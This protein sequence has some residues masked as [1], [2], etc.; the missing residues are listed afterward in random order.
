MSHKY[1]RFSQ[2]CE[3][4][5]RNSVLVDVIYIHFQ[6]AFEKDPY[7]SQL[8]KL[9][10]HGI[11]GKILTWLENLLSEKEKKKTTRGP[12]WRSIELPR[13]FKCTKVRFSA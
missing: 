4:R 1:A 13:R 9:A 12:N 7:K 11:S 6:K 8:N 5:I 3:H 2:R 10:S